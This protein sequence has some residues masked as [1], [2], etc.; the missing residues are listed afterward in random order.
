ML[1]LEGERATF[2]ERLRQHK[3]T[4]SGS[5]PLLLTDSSFTLLV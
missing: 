1:R 5:A 2:L 3:L 4:A